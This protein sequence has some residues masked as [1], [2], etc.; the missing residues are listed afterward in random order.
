MGVT[1][2]AGAAAETGPSFDCDMA[3]TAIEKRICGSPA[4]AAMDQTVAARYTALQLDIQSKAA[5]TGIVADQ[6]A[7]LRDRDACG[8]RRGPGRA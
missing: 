1:L 8:D 2:A 6:R 3:R 4:L 7:W 5:R